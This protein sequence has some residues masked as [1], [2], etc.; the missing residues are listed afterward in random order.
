MRRGPADHDHAPHPLILEKVDTTNLT[1]IVPDQGHQKLVAVIVEV[2]NQAVVEDTPGQGPDHPRGGG[3]A[4]TLAPQAHT[5]SVS[6]VEVVDAIMDVKG[7]DHQCHGEGA[8][9][10]AGTT[11]K[12]APALE[13]LA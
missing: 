10:A 8:T 5:M 9:Q 4:D 12:K 6:A 7:L 13:C 2:A 11:L 1:W 3:L